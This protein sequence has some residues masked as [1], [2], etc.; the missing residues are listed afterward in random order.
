[1]IHENQVHPQFTIRGLQRQLQEEAIEKES[2]DIKITNLAKKIL[3]VTTIAAIASVLAFKA[4]VILTISVIT[5]I[6]LIALGINNYFFSLQRIFGKGRLIPKKAI[7]ID[8]CSEQFKQDLPRVFREEEQVIYIQLNDIPLPQNEEEA[9]Q[10]I[11]NTTRNEEFT[12][13]ILQVLNQTLGNDL[14][15]KTGIKYSTRDINVINLINS[16]EDPI[17]WNVKTAEKVFES[18]QSFYLA[19]DWVENYSPERHK[20]ILAHG[21]HDL[22]KNVSTYIWKEHQ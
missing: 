12:L 18:Y 14:S 1:M 9:I 22:K 21:R 3:I 15:E 4:T 8:E 17:I 11:R 5:G 16:R 20:K 7:S 10:E 2:K 6:C 19:R 13:Q